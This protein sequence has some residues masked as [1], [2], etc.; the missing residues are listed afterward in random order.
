MSYSLA[1]PQM[2][3]FLL[4]LQETMDTMWQYNTLN[5]VTE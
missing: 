4:A 3:L 2:V 1:T 5:T